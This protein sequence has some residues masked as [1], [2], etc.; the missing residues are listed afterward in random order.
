MA[1][2]QEA[3]LLNETEKEQTASSFISIRKLI[4]L[5]FFGAVVYLIIAFLAN[6]AEVSASLSL[7]PL[8]VIPAML[9]FSFLNYVIRYFKWQY[10]W[11]SR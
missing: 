1:A 11:N 10:M 9:G 3:C 2:T 7:I 6:I 8:W 5:V 4:L